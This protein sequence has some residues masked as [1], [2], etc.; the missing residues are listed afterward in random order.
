MT[1]NGETRAGLTTPQARG[2]SPCLPNKKDLDGSV[3]GFK[4]HDFGD[5]DLADRLQDGS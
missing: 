1:T 2:P 3:E 4:S 5:G